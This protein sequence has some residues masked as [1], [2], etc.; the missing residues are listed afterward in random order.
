M[1]TIYQ[2][3]HEYVS[4]GSG[5]YNYQYFI[6]IDYEYFGRVSEK[7]LGCDSLSSYVYWYVPDAL[8]FSNANADNQGFLLSLRSSVTYMGE[9]R[10]Y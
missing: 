3:L 1:L 8:F 9:K 6:G 10:Y 5:D 2:S 4:V 7:Q